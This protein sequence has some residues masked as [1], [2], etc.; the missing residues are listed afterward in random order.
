[1]NK[2]WIFSILAMLLLSG[3]AIGAPTPLVIYGKAEFSG[4]VYANAEVVIRDG[5]GPIGA[6]YTSSKGV[7]LVDVAN[8]KHPGGN[9][10]SVGETLYLEICPASEC[11]K[12]VKV[13]SD[14]VEVNFGVSQEPV[15]VE[16]PIV[17]DD[18][19]DDDDVVCDVEDKV[20]PDELVCDAEACAD[21]VKDC[22]PE[23]VAGLSLWEILAGIL[24]GLGAGAGG[25]FVKRKEAISK[26]VGLKIYKGVSGEEKVLHKH[27]GIKGYHDPQVRHREVHERH[28]VGE[29]TPAYVKDAN[30]VWIYDG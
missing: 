15:I 27:P 19:E 13:G 22:E 1:M 26:G 18:V 5:V 10:I 7:Y 29:L 6:V 23:S 4:N 21:F 20:C 17:D 25:Y 8:L 24:I 14:P 11:K 28:D 12:S 16:P 30:G 9:S 3:V 2:L